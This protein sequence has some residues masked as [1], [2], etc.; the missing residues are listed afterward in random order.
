METSDM[1][2]SLHGNIKIKQ[3]HVSLII[4]E[5]EDSTRKIMTEF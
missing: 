2:T 4:S 1:T 5:L 3:A